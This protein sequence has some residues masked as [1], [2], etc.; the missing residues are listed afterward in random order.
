MGISFQGGD[1]KG[2]NQKPPFPSSL[3]EGGFHMKHTHKSDLNLQCL[4]ML[5]AH[6]WLW[7]S[8]QSQ[9]NICMAVS[10]MFHAASCSV[11]YLDVM[12]LPHSE[13]WAD[14]RRTAHLT[15]LHQMEGNEQFDIFAFH[16]SYLY[17]MYCSWLLHDETLQSLVWPI[18]S[19]PC[20][21]VKEQV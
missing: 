9:R 10:A 15:F 2:L 18:T 13:S 5:T 1:S 21:W 19:H 17:C 6:K 11:P 16:C 4:K 14:C 12:K 20:L 3:K 8:S 7:Y